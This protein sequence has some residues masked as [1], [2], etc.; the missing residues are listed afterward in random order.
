MA[1]WQFWIDRGGTFTDVVAKTPQ[2]DIL[3]HKLLS[4]D[5]EHYKDA[6]IAGIRHFLDVSPQQPIPTDRIGSVRMGTTVATNALLERKGDR[7]ALLTNQGLE[8]ALRIADQT[9]PQLFALNVQLPEMLYEKVVAIPERIDCHGRDRVEFDL[10]TTESLLLEIYQHGIQ[11]IAIVL[12]HGYKHPQHEQ[13]IAQLA[14]GIGFDYVACSHEVSPLIKFVSRGDTAVVDAY[15][16]PILHR[17]LQGITQELP[18][19]DLKFMQSSGGLVNADFFRGKDSI[20]SGPAGGIVGAAKTSLAAGFDQIVTFDMGGTST[21][22]AHFAGEYER[23]YD[24]LVAGIR[25]RVAM[26]KIHTIAA[27]GGSIIKFDQGRFQVG[28]ESAGAFPG[29]ASYRNQGPLTIT[30]CNI[31]LGKIQAS[32]F[33]AVFGPK[34][35]QALDTKIVHQKFAQ[36]THDINQHTGQARSVA[37]IAEGFIKIAVDSMANAIKKISVQK[38]HD[39]LKHT[40]C[41]FGGAG[42]QHACD[43]ADQLGVRTIMI[44]PHAGVLSAY[45]MGLA[46]MNV[47]RSKMI[48]QLLEDGFK[49]LSDNFT[50]LSQ[51]AESEMAKQGIRQAKTI[52]QRKL[53][54]KY[55][56]T[57]SVIL[58]DYQQC[59]SDI[60]QAFLDAHQKRYGFILPG[61]P[62]EIDMISVDLIA[63]VGQDLS[64][65]AVLE[66][67]RHQPEPLAFQTVFLA[68]QWHDTPIYRRDQLVAGHQISGPALIIESTGTNVITPNWH[69]KITARGDLVLS[70]TGQKQRLNLANSLDK[71]DPI[72]LEVF[73]NL[74]MSIAEEM[75]EALANTAYSV[76]IKERRD[77]SCAIFNTKGELVANAPHMPVHL[78]SMS[79][80]VSEIIQQRRVNMQPG[81]VFLLNDPYHGGTHLPDMTVITP[82]FVKQQPQKPVFY[83]ASRGHHADIGGNTPGSMPS[84]STNINQEGILFTNFH[85][86]KAGVFQQQAYMDALTQSPYPARNP[87]QNI[88]DVQAQIAANQKGVTE[89]AKMVELHGLETVQCYMQF[90]QD[91]AEQSVQ[92]LLPTLRSG[93][94]TTQMDIGCQ[95]VVDIQVDADQKTATLDF[96]GTSQQGQHNYNAPLAITYAAILYVFRA[97]VDKNIPLN[98]GCLK[99]LKVMMPDN[100]MLNPKPPAAVVAGNVETSQVIV[101]TLLSAMNI[102]AQA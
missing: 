59:Q 82:V 76:N 36:L 57:D 95:I 77:F 89:I 8:D 17:Y 45:G 2:G 21:D 80:S 31:A 68:G 33:P 15:L 1:K 11:S 28:P 32:H 90:V 100:C 50:Q 72:L 63:M 42:G 74:F 24:T 83:V 64:E 27:G 65:V 49:H 60:E 91:N 4:E 5:P 14:R 61:K 86:V 30:D 67:T 38:G 3:T 43:I 23:D 26:M 51:Q 47:P 102:C 70:Q 94:F 69:G 48:G 35:D 7:I 84:D 87:Q 6:S 62:I 9:R 93:R 19:V 56:G 78:G 44:H 99:P 40:L 25:M 54:L 75:G 58:I 16:S 34:Q 96:T 29:P 55:Q 73:N 98:Y 12:M 39:I 81:D 37:Q 71:P 85:L 97:L 46:D 52:C 20:L 88:G 79:A 66:S 10:A 41:C 13:K 18:G 53:H 22:V 92:Q 101:N